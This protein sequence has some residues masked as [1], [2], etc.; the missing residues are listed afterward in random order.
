MA[1]KQTIPAGIAIAI[2]SSVFSQKNVVVVSADVQV[3]GNVNAISDVTVVKDIPL[4]LIG[5]SIRV[6]VEEC[7]TISEQ[8]ADA[9]IT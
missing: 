4:E 9:E 8:R 6:Q 1:T 3:A 2:P 7:V 5:N